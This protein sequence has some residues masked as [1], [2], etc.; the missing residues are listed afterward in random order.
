M[1]TYFDEH[2]C[3]ELAEGETPDHLL[4]FARLLMDAGVWDQVKNCNWG[5][6]SKKCISS[7]KQIIYPAN[8]IN[9]FTNFQEEFDAMFRQ[10]NAPPPASKKFVNS[11][12]DVQLVNDEGT[13]G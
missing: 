11:L 3:Q 12:D 2:N 6:I 10:G 9:H 5:L 8:Q 4:H 13:Y 1:A 7:F